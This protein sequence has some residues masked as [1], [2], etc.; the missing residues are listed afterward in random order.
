MNDVRTRAC[1]ALV[2]W[3]EIETMFFALW[4]PH[5]GVLRE[6]TVPR[7]PVP[8]QTIQKVNRPR[9]VFRSCLRI[10][11]RLG[12]GVQRYLSDNQRLNSRQTRFRGE[13]HAV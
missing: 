12:G 10:P 7:E 1:V 8:S 4:A 9:F 3:R 6:S 13:I 2:Q 11:E 5:R